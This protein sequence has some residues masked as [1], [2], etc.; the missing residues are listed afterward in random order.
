MKSIIIENQKW[1]DEVWGRLDNKLSRI[2][3]KS[4][5]KIPYT[6][7]NGVHNDKIVED[8]GSWTNGFWAGLMWV[9]YERTRNEDYRITAEVAEKAMDKAFEDYD[10]L[11]HDVGFMWHIMSCANYRLIGNR[12]SRLRS[13]YAPSLLSSRYNISGHF[14]RAWNKKWRG[15]ETKGITV[16][17]SMMNLPLLYWA[18]DEIGDDRFKKIAIEHANM[19]IRDHVREDGSIYHIVEHDTL[20]GEPIRVMSGQ[21]YSETSCW[22]RGLAWMVYGSVLSYVHTG[23][24]KYLEASMR[25][26]DY[27]IDH[28]SKNG[29][30][31]VIDFGAPAEPVYYDSTA[32]VCAACGMLE[33]A[34]NTTSEVSKKYCT[35]AINILKATY[36]NFCNFGENEDSIVQMGSCSYP[37]ENFDSVHI[38]I[39][40]GD[41]FF[42][43]AMAKLKG[44]DFLIW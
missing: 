38:P 23:D 42:A 4:R 21:G 20:T 36:E 31:T 5:G 35:E 26:A 37:Y 16:I 25:S 3:V 14:I 8:I 27:F 19:T 40:Y 7:Y 2:A 30:K 11:G 6:T 17:D 32:G 18:S 33:I 12:K 24:K 9:M 29:Y 1:I 13:L 10:R 41:F 43:E 28:C 39:I 34:R 15:Y 22:T 44:T